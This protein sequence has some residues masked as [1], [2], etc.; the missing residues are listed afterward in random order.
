MY[1]EIGHS[2]S[3]TVEILWWLSTFDLSSESANLQQ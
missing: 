3:T 1:S 2:P